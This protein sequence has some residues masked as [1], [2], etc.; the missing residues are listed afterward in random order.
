MNEIFSEKFWAP[1]ERIE[2]FLGRHL[3]LN[4]V[5]RPTPSFGTSDI[6][7]FRFLFY[8]GEVLF[9]S[10]ILDPGSQVCGVWC[11]YGVACESDMDLDL[12]G[13]ETRFTTQLS[14]VGRRGIK[15]GLNRRNLV[16]I[17]SMEKSR[18]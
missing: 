5:F 14:L 12:W 10:W 13:L 1:K 9:H 7:G 3:F 2:L 16:R 8:L 18:G 11:V 4:L 6:G 17:T 15:R